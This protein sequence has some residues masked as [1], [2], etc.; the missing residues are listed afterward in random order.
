MMH[1]PTGANLVIKS[2][3]EYMEAVRTALRKAGLPL[4]HASNAPN[5]DHYVACAE[6]IGD[7]DVVAQR[8]ADGKIRI[9]VRAKASAAAH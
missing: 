5:Y 4:T 6:V 3:L 9:L 2:E 7:G 8:A 1:V